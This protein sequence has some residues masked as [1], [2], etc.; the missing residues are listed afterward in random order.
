VSGCLCRRLQQV[1]VFAAL[2]IAILPGRG[3]AAPLRNGFEVVA[4]ALR[5][6]V[7]LVLY[8]GP[9]GIG[10]L[11]AATVGEQGLALLGP[12][13]R[14]IAGVWAAQAVMALVYLALMKALT[15]RSPVSFLRDT[16]PLYATTAA[17]CS[18]M[19]SPAVA[20]QMRK[21]SCG[22]QSIYSFTLALGANMNRTA[23][24]TLAAPALQ[25]RRLASVSLARRSRSCWSA[26]SCRAAP[27]ES[28]AAR[29]W[30]RC[31]SFSPS[32]C[33]WR[34]RRSWPALSAD[35][36][37]QHHHQRHGRS[38]WNRDRCRHGSG[39]RCQPSRRSACWVLPHQAHAEDRGDLAS[40]AA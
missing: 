17:T 22:C 26:W 32:T 19:A 6:L 5:S 20:L 16:A 4:Q 31:S 2:R 21:T 30:S 1:V 40:R 34:S 14:F 38:G 8:V 27:R 10:A 25:P 33:R 23:L 11:T 36:H 18:S 12:L 37:G 24:I 39:A 15:P 29:W 9:L 3:R 35:R 28:L 13:A 7:R